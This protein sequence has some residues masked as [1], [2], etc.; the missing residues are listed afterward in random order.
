VFIDNVN[1]RTVTLPSRLKAE[2]VIV[3]PN[4]F[5]EQFNIW[6]VQA[7]ADL[8]YVNV[9]TASGQL[10]WKK[11]YSSGSPSNIINVSMSG[12]AAGV[13]LIKLGYSD[14]GK[15]KEIRIIKSN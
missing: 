13:Y 8:R 11:E 14:K 7:P 4:P 12:M 1:F 10:I 2:G 5:S 15:D 9:L 6:F 3:T